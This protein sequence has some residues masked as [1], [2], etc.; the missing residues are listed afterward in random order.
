MQSAYAMI[1]IV[2]LGGKIP[3]SLA[4]WAISPPSS[5]PSPLIFF[6][7]YKIKHCLLVDYLPWR[8]TL[9]GI[10]AESDFN[11]QGVFETDFQMA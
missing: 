5:T 6:F 10:Q 1:Q 2:N 3:C 11:L 8:N 7:S 4:G 9:T